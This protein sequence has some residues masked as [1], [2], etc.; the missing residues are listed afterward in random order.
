MNKPRA[1]IKTV[2]TV[3]SYEPN[4]TDQAALEGIFQDSQWTL[5]PGL[6]WQLRSAPT[7]QSALAAMRKAQIPLVVC[8]CDV[9]PETWKEILGKLPQ[10]ANP[11]LLIVTSRLADDRLWVEALNLGAYDVLAK[12]YDSSEVVRTFS[13]AWLRW[14]GHGGTTAGPARLAHGKAC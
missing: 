4:R 2:I 10:V 5:C 13:S 12:P 8:G 9:Q 7:L 11:P 6:E 14:Q 3:L 1:N